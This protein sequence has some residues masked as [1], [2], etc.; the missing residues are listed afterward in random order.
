MDKTKGIKIQNTHF[1]PKHV[2]GSFLFN[3]ELTSLQLHL[4]CSSLASLSA[5]KL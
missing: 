3:T 2:G 5:Q 1:N 4:C